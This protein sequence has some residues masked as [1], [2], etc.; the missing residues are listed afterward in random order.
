MSSSSRRTLPWSS[1]I[2]ANA[3]AAHSGSTSWP[4]VAGAVTWWCASDPA[5]ATVLLIRR[6]VDGSCHDLLGPDWSL[7]NKVNGYGGKPYAIDGDRLVFTHS[8]DGRLYL[9]DPYGSAD[10]VPTALTTPAE[11]GTALWY[12]D[13]QLID[14]SDLAYC[15]REI[16]V[17]SPADS[18][19]AGRTSRAIVAVPLSGGEL[20]VLAQSHHFLS[21]VRPSPDGRQLAWI[22]WNHPDMPWDSTEL[23]VAP[24]TDG[25]A[26]QAR[27]LFGGGQISIP[28]AEW[29]GSDT[30][31]AMADPAGWWNLHRVDVAGAAVEC[32]LPM[33]AECAGPLW[34]VG[35]TWFAVAGNRIV[36][37]PADGDQT[38]KLWQP[39]TG[40]LTDL[41]PG[42]TQF[43][44]HVSADAEAAVVTA[45]SAT[46]TPTVLRVPLDG[47]PPQACSATG[48][49][50][51]R[52]WLSIPQRRVA[53]DETGQPVHYLWYPPTNPGYDQDGPAPLLI[54]VHGGPT[55]RTSSIPN[56]EFSLFTSRGFA[57]ASVNYGGSTGHGRP[58]RERLRHNWGIVDV[59]DCVTVIRSL[60]AGGEADP[61]RVAVRGGSAG[62]WTSLACIASTEAFC[63][64]AV[65]YPISDAFSWSGAETHD[66]E[67]RYLEGLIGRLPADRARYEAV[68]PLGHVDEIT[69]PLVM[70]QGADDPICPPV[71]AH[72]IVD[73]VAARGLWHRLLVFDGEGHGFR[74]ASSVLDSLRAE[75]ELYSHTMGFNLDLDDDSAL[76]R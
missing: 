11:D 75:A 69:V 24:L 50:P 33:Q 26:G 23:M 14:G 32:V 58:Y 25:K 63:A 76:P 3:V 15:V 10:Q 27:M 7:A 5:T 40:E 51:L 9:A 57:V 31:Y 41:A 45:G 60:V 67:S 12:A 48:D 65:Y 74:K 61:E 59:A 13:V 6:D 29:L 39:A 43:G 36:L 16:T 22:G 71:H 62:G 34:Q 46:N 53:E 1:P 49:D 66:F 44:S 2:T 64:A 17:L 47:A 28:Q 56:L 54:H 55:S 72:T 19:P 18:D 8:G 21:N 73:A 52:G 20:S 35:S 38:L 70:L 30:L 4:S 42:W 68:S 37:A